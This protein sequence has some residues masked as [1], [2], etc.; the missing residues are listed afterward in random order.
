MT[1][2]ALG[3]A[4]ISRPIVIADVEPELDGGRFP[5]KRE[6][7]D[8][9]TVPASIL[10]DGHDHLTAVL[11]TRPA[12]GAQWRE[13]PMRLVN[14]GLDRWS[15]TVTLTENALWVYTVEA[16][17]DHFATWHSEVSKKLA[18]G[19]D[20]ALEL[21]EGREIVTA[22][23]ARA[24]GRDRA[25]LQA[26]AGRFDEVA[27]PTE[28]T[29][30]MLSPDLGA[31]LARWPDRTQAVSYDRE[32]GV[33]V[34]RVAARYAA[35][36]EMFPR[37]QG[38]VAGRSATFAECERRLPAIRDM[39]FD[40]V[41]LVPIHPIGRSHRKGPNNSLS[42]G[43]GD[44][45]SPYAIGA[46]EGGHTAVHPDLGTLEDF[47]HFVGETNRLG[48]EVALDIAIQCSPDHP[49]VREHPE[50]FLFRPDGTIKYAENPPKKYQDIVNVNFFGPH[51]DA[52]WQELK[53]VFE[54]WI[55]QG[56][57]VFRVDNP[58]TKPVPFWEWCIGEIKAAH[59]EVI[60]LSESFTRP[61]M[62]KM[63]AK[64]GYSQS[65]TYFTWRN[66]K[67]D[68]V[69]YLTELTRTET[70]EYLRPNFFTSTPDI[71]PEYLQ[72]GGRPAFMVRQV[73]AAT[74]SSVY[75]IYNGF[76]LC[77]NQA[78]PGKEE[79]LNSEKYD[80]KVWDWDRPGNII[81]L[82]TA[83]NRIRKENPALQELDTL[84]FYEADDGNVLFYGKMTPDRTNMIFVAVNLDP[85]DA[86]DSR[87]HFPLTE[88]G[89]GEHDSFEVEDLLS[90]RKHLWTGAG[91]SIHLDPG[92]L[93]AAIFRVRVWQRIDY[94][95]PC[96]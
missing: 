13:A 65:Y 31:M 22:A 80:Y 8:T 1:I 9:L 82:I 12:T 73:L 62:L 79:Y 71:L 59:P 17:T 10:R 7:G 64:V 68:L 28:R 16:W 93:P 11:K 43:P 76:E 2:H 45:G 66:F 14:S 15:G 32:L 94:A 35:W 90:G 88:M 53:G 29:A 41:Y 61:P 75:G 87:L 89:L 72:K 18:A 78:V 44:P 38:T 83:V 40:T 27:D 56:V 19:Q 36:Y 42:A 49:W 30:L 86:H 5:I 58:H 46:V 51:Q 37:S 70:V 96:G 55:G 33:M 20:I 21:I 4:P 69:D 54:F 52:L 6:V 39:G 3:P 57:K 34:D 63:L 67:Q 81:S 77:E 48:M 50:W 85:F 91:H 24:E 74:L 26:L 23:A 47:R 25:R 84:R 60:F 92:E 95:T